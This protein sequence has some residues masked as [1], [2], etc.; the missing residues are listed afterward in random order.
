ML[1]TT[2]RGIDLNLET[3]ALDGLIQCAE[4]I[5]HRKPVQVVER[6]TSLG[7]KDSKGGWRNVPSR[8]PPTCL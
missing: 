7:K 4:D 2:K 6:L 8:N 5:E 1:I 3:P